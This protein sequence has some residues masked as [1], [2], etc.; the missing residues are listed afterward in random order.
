MNNFLFIIYNAQRVYKSSKIKKRV[1]RPGLLRMLLTDPS[2]AIDSE[3][4]LPSLHNHFEII[5]EK[6]LGWNITQL[7]FKDISHHFYN[8][9]TQ[10]TQI[11]DF[12]F[13]EED[14]FVNETDKSDGI[15]GIYK[16]KI[17]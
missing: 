9:S 3:S 4:I 15:F 6:T 17:T 12:I 10:T 11:L 13:N 5:E 8:N 14:K 7:L 2:E 1:Y 16:P